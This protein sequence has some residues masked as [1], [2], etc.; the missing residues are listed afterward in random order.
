L[1]AILLAFQP[2]CFVSGN[3]FGIG[4][5][6][7][8]SGVAHIAGRRIPQQKEECKHETRRV[9][10]HG[11]AKQLVFLVAIAVISS[12]TVAFGQAGQL[13]STFGTGGIFTTNF[14]QT[15]L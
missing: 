2:S 4:E 1:K 6:H 11:D 8:T 14:T 15:G 7:S 12:S 5:Y 10:I 9:P 13:D 3:I